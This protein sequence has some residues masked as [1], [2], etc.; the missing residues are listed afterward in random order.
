MVIA[1]APPEAFVLALASGMW[2]PD[3]PELAA[4]R[5]TP[6][7]GWT[8][9]ETQAWIDAHWHTIED[10]LGD[11]VRNEFHDAAELC[12]RAD[13]ADFARRFDAVN[14]DLIGL[15]AHHADTEEATYALIAKHD[16]PQS[17]APWLF[18]HAK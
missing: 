5:M 16:I 13:I 15:A 18:Q 9:T 6:V 8:P 3:E 14:A 17:I 11:G 4:A 2:N 12:S 1:P 7:L 10:I